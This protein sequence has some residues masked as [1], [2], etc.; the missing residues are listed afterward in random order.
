MSG[1]CLRN[2][3]YVDSYRS[4]SHCGATSACRTILT[5]RGLPGHSRPGFPR[6]GTF[7]RPL[8][9]TVSNG[10]LRTIHLASNMARRRACKFHPDD[11]DS[12]KLA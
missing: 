5:P 10:R 3:A 11:Q 6:V 7:S 8:L 4:T 1:N 2:Y 9:P 12:L